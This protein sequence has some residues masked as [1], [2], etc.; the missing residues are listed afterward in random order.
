MDGSDHVEFEM[1]LQFAGHLAGDPQFEGMKRKVTIT[2][3][4]ILKAIGQPFT[5]PTQDLYDEFFF[6]VWMGVRDA[7][8]QKK[9]V[10]G[11]IRLDV[12]DIKEDGERLV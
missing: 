10:D 6:D 7:A 5:A 2:R 3:E 4:A 11:A 9:P 8:W 1:P 12:D